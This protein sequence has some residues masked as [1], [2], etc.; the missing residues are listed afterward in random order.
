LLEAGVFDYS[1]FTSLPCCG[2]LIEGFHDLDILTDSLERFSPLTNFWR[3]YR[4]QLAKSESVIAIK[5]ATC[6]RLSGDQVVTGLE[7]ASAGNARFEVR[8]RYIVLA[9]GGLEVVRILGHSGY[10]NHSGMLGRTYMCHVEAAL[11]KL[12]LSPAHRGVQ[13]G[14]DRTTDGIYCRRRFTLLAE[15]QERLGILN[16][17]IRLHHANIVDPSHRHPVL[18]GMFLAKKLF[19]PE[20]VRNFTVV[21]RKAMHSFNN[22][23]GLWLWHVHNV[24]LDIP[25]FVHFALGWIFRRYLAYPGIPH[26]ALRNETGIYPLDFNGEQAPNLESRVLLARETDRYG[27]PRLKIDWR[28]SELDRLTLSGMLRELERA[29]EGCGCGTIE[30]EEARLNQGAHDIAPLGGHHIGTTRMSENPNAGVVDGD[31]R[32][33]YMRN[34]YVAGSATLPTSGQANPMLTIVAMALRLARHLEVKLD[35]LLI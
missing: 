3:R 14:F 21:E 35:G 16:G 6:L 11:G 34:L 10:G 8:T 5:R 25:R 9:V 26:V 1:A 22:N 28:T 30:C 4:A 12:R 2:A 17:A 23:M 33:H 27:V 31:G 13:F 24:L 18:S 19:I 29:V 7:C 15:K 32:V 20:C